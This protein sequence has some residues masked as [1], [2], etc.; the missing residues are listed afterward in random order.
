MGVTDTPKPAVHRPAQSRAAPAPSG[1]DG[2]D[3]PGVHGTLDM[4]WA[5]ISPS[6]LPQPTCTHVASSIHPGWVSSP[7]LPFLRNSTQSWLVPGQ[8]WP[9]SL[10]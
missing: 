1:C 7:T 5:L 9:F 6:S 8:Q 3:V 2:E 10:F 4:D